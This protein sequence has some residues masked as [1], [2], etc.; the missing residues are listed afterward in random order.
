LRDAESTLGQLLALGEKTIDVDT[1]SL[2]LPVT[3]VSSAIDLLESLSRNNA[4]ECLDHLGVFVTQGGS[5]RHL[6]DECLSLVR[7]LLFIQLGSSDIR[8]DETT[9]ERLTNLASS[10]NQAKTRWLLDALLGAK[11][12]KSSDIFPQLP[13]ELMCVE[14]VGLF[15]EGNVEEPP[16]PPTPPPAAKKEVKPV[17]SAETAK[18]EPK[19]VTEEPA[20]QS[21][22]S[23]DIQIEDLIDMPDEPEPVPEEI[24][25]E[26][27]ESPAAAPVKAEPDNVEE[28]QEEA[29]GEAS[30]SVEDLAAKWK[31]CCELVS[32]ENIALPLVLNK[33]KPLKVKGSIVEIGFEHRFHYDTMQQAKNSDMLMR[34]I[35]EVM[36]KSVSLEM[37]YMEQ[38]VDDTVDELVEAFGGS[39][40]A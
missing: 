27:K 21:T 26:Q 12:K 32:K 14:F 24:K 2:V 18:P 34:A 10:L 37:V 22:S 15:S 40:V 39:V 11:V 3:Y 33:A 35:N 25:V 4:K 5:I 38:N 9:Q 16:A 1:A 6:I 20:S 36:Q 19:K 7:A 29:H 17:A 8:Y 28:G 31:R 13:L 23:A 30:F